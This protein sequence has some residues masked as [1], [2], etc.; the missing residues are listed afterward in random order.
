[1]NLEDYQQAIIS[2]VKL[3]RPYKKEIRTILEKEIKTSDELTQ[4]FSLPPEIVAK[5]IESS[6]SKVYNNEIGRLRYGYIMCVSIPVVYIIIWIIHVI[7]TPKP[8]GFDSFYR[9]FQDFFLHAAIPR[10]SANLLLFIVLCSFG[11]ALLERQLLLSKKQL[12]VLEIIFFI[13][14]GLQHPA[15]YGVE[16]WPIIVDIAVDTWSFSGKFVWGI[17]QPQVLLTIFTLLI[18]T[19]FLIKKFGDTGTF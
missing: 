16:T 14:L 13:I 17:L 5:N 15:I 10:V 6:Y 12:F 7:S 19:R 3:P 2:H 4:T 8:G 1:M 9:Y 18:N 11:Y